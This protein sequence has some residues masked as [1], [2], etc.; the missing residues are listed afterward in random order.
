MS[1][2]KNIV[3]EEL[4]KEGLD[5]AE[6]AL[7]GVVKALFRA[8]PRILPVSVAAVVAAVLISVEPTVLALVDKLDGQDDEGR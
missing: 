4:K 6:D 2:E 8:I 3:L 5:I 1:E 7:A